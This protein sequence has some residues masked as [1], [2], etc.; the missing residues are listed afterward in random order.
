M[1][2]DSRLHGPIL[3]ILSG[4][5]K[6]FGR[7]PPRRR[8]PRRSSGEGR[9]SGH[10]LCTQPAVLRAREHIAAGNWWVVDLDLEKFL[11]GVGGRQS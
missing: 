4:M 9:V 6:Q 8:Q 5:G 2:V 11:G 1:D 3:T 7:L 10:S